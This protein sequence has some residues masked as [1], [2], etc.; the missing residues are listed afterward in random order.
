MDTCNQQPNTAKYCTNHSHQSGD[1]HSLMVGNRDAVQMV[2]ARYGTDLHNYFYNS[3]NSHFDADDLLQ[4]LYGRLLSYHQPIR[5]QSLNAFV[6]TIA[7]NLLRDRSRRVYSRH[8]PHTISIDDI[9]EVDEAEQISID[10][11]D[12]SRV[13]GGI[14]ELE[15]VNHEL[16]N[17]QLEC[18]KAFCL[19]RMRGLNYKQIASNM[20]VTVSMVEKHIMRVTRKLR[21][22]TRKTD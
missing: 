14:E 19:H 10:T 11:L 13:A 6:H 1:A 2:A 17:M 12:P 7:L 5:L 15:Q 18:K 9:D 4:D 20:G 22:A 16:T 8:L 3:L 21:K